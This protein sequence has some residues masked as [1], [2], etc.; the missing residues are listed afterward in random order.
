[1]CVGYAA[2]GSASLGHVVKAY[3]ERPDNW[4]RCQRHPQADEEDQSRSTGCH[5]DEHGVGSHLEPSAS[6]LK[7]ELTMKGCV[8][9]FGSSTTVVPTRIWPLFGSGGSSKDSVILAFSL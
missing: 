8:R 1:M 5:V 4:E 7:C 6:F 2:C 9:Y 3:G